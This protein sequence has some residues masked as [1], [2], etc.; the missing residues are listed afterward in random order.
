MLAGVMAASPLTSFASTQ[1]AKNITIA[2]VPWMTTDPFFISMEVGAQQEAKALG[3]TLLWQGA[4]QY[5]PSQQTP[6]VNAMIAKKVS[7]LIVCPTDL[8]AMIPPL[9]AAVKAGIPVIT[10]DS[11]I[12]DT[13]ILT[14]RVTADNVQGGAAAADYIARS[15]GGKG[16]VA[17]LDPKPGISTDDQR[18]QG[19]EKEIKKYKGIQFVGI[20][21][22]NEQTSTA[23][24]LARDLV[25]RYPHL[26][27]IFGTDD[28]SASG[29][30]EGI[31]SAGKLGKVKVVAY[32]AEPAE[33]KDLQQGLISALIAQ[34]PMLE[35]KLAV[36]YA[37]D[38]VMGKTAQIKKFMQLPNVIITKANLASNTQWEYKSSAN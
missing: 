23:S 26:A 32:D 3:V 12:S 2:F 37:Y 16:Q 6:Y 25:L 33:V 17:I 22:D 34:K 4:S 1:T 10:A 28:T 7:A 18:V 36:E 35:G 13:S 20:Q 8:T 19:F 21:Y 30:A 14:S 24:T 38:K 11:T 9:K 15:V 31:R 27:G 29:A 5:A